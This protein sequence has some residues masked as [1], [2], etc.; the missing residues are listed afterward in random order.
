MYLKVTLAGPDNVDQL[1]RRVVDDILTLPDIEDAELVRLPAAPGEKGLIE[2]IGTIG[3]S[4]LSAG[5]GEILLDYLK[6]TLSQMAAGPSEKT[7]IV[8]LDGKR[9]ELRGTMSDAEFAATTDRI[10]SM[11][12]GG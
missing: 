2:Q 8:E 4:I 7:I 6:T 1:S 12:K 10:L 9:A 11:M 3:V 5:G